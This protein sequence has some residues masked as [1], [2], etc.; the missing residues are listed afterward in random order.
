[1]DKS[2]NSYIEDNNIIIKLLDIFPSINDLKQK[3]N[4]MDIIFQ[5][6]DIFY[7]LFE[8]LTNHKEITLKT[9]NKS[10][11]IISLIKSNTLF[12]TCVFNIK[13]GD[14]WISFSYENKRK[15]DSSLAQSLIDCIKIKLNCEIIQNKNNHRINNTKKLKNNLSNNQKINYG[16]MLTEDNNIK[17]QSFIDPNFQKLSLNNKLFTNKGNKRISLESSP[18]ENILEKSKFTW[19]KNNNTIN[20]NT[21]S[22]NHNHFENIINKKKNFMD[23]NNNNNNNNEEK[24]LRRIKTKNSY[25]KII[26][27]D[28]AIRLNKIINK[29][30]ENKLNLTQRRRKNNNSNNINSNLDYSIKGSKNCSNNLLFNNFGTN[31]SQKKNKQIL[32]NRLLYNTNKKTE[33]KNITNEYNN[34]KN[35]TENSI[36]YINN[37]NNSSNNYDMNISKRRKYTNR[38]ERSHDNIDNLN[39]GVGTMTNRRN[40]DVIKDLKNNTSTNAKTPEITRS[41]KYTIKNNNYN[42]NT[43]DIDKYTLNEDYNKKDNSIYKNIFSDLDYDNEEEQNKYF[44]E[45]SNNS[46]DE[47]NN[48]ERLREDFIL[49]YND[50]YVKNVQEDLLK[51]EIELFVEKMTGLISAYHYE[52]NKRKLQNKIIENNLKENSEKYINLFKLYCKLNLIK[53]NYKKKYLRFKKNKTNIKALNDKNFDANK[54][55]IELFKIIFPNKNNGKIKDKNNFIDKKGELKN[56]INNLLSKIHN[57]N[58]INKTDLYKKW[59]GINKEK[60]DIINKNKDLN[61]IFD[62]DKKD[63]K[64]KAR[65]RVIPKLQQTKFNSKINIYNN[66]PNI[67]SFASNENKSEKKMINNKKV[68][69]NNFNYF[70]HNP[71]KD[72]FSKSS[73]IYSKYYSRKIAK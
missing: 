41:N 2:K 58:I 65:T 28:L 59:C 30:D 47:N 3:N 57:K 20:T 24:G 48:Y 52:I 55:E 37:M 31:K 26:D 4:E 21:S 32:K 9:N 12:A 19:I 68:E 61:T 45:L 22:N 6:L 64:P 63:K 25:S 42:K 62:E 17:S 40:K 56:V 7:N 53:K 13:K 27:E 15:K 23:D 49:L 16:S 35:E 60:F 50:D 8:L 14:Q 11:I 73:A 71:S 67:N 34:K 38:A 5:G 72:T 29:S 70:T 46:F 36:N 18:K 39:I 51:L 44:D 69:T 54:K 10:S 43:V 66:E 1:M 33:I